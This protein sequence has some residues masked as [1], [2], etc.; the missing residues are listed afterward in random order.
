MGYLK[1]ELPERINGRPYQVHITSD[2]EAKVINGKRV[3]RFHIVVHHYGGEPK[4]EVVDNL[5]ALQTLLG[6]LLEEK[7][8]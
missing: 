6:I 8:A 1:R 4:V 2:T 3:R 5:Y 7:P